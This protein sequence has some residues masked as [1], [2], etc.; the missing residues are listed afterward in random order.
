VIT[1][2]RQKESYDGNKKN[3]V[4]FIPAYSESK[5]SLIKTIKSVEEAVYPDSKKCIVVVV[6]GRIRGTLNNKPTS[7]Y[8]KEIFQTREPLYESREYQIFIGLYNNVSFILIIKEQNKGKKDSF[9]ILQKLLLNYWFQDTNLNFIN[10]FRNTEYILVLDTDTNIGPT[11]I[12][13]LS[14]YLDSHQDTLA[15]CGETFIANSGDNLITMSQKFEYWVTHK[16]MKAIE[17]VYSDVLV[18]SGCFTMYRKTAIAN[19]NI[20][21]KYSKEEDNN[22]Y[23]ANTTKLGEDRLLTNLLLQENSNLNTKYIEQ[24]KCYTDCPSDIK[25][26]LCQRRRWTNSLIFCHLKLIF[27]PPDYSLFRLIRFYLVLFVQLLTVI[28]LPILL[29]LAYV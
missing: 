16:T 5:E 27:N 6:D 23:L 11:S 26:L 7:D 13:V 20:I 19:E 25:T 4:I 14:M 24:A 3:I 15:V 12:N 2:T 10:Y 1:W 8:A 28:I 18:L 22:L 9:L 21:E 29:L 17:S